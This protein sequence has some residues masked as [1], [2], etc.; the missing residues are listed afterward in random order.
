MGHDIEPAEAFDLSLEL[1][2]APLTVAREPAQRLVG[3]CRDHAVLFTSLLRQQ[4]IPARV[5]AGFATYLTSSYHC[6][7]WVVQ[8]W[9]AAQERWL[10]VD[11]QIDDLQREKHGIAFD[12]FDMLSVKHFYLAGEAWQ[13]CRSGK[14]RSDRFGFTRWKGW[15]YLRRQLLHDVDALNRV[16]LLPWDGFG[17][18]MSRSERDVTI[19]DRALLDRL[20][21]LTLDVDRRLD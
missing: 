15:P 3:N 21:A 4:G 19:E 1:D 14:E 18:L 8:V 10:L 17:D 9:D 5:R 6:D 12:T 16:E 7:H 13:L 20:A 2:P 11:P